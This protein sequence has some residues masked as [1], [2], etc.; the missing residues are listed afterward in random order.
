MFKCFDLDHN[1]V[2]S[3]KEL[4]NLTRVEAHSTGSDWSADRG[5]RLISEMDRDSNGKISE[6]EFIASFEP[7]L[8]YNIEVFNAAVN[9]FCDSAE[10]VLDELEEKRSAKYGRMDPYERA[11]KEAEDATRRARLE[12]ARATLLEDDAGKGYE[13]SV[14]AHAIAVT[15]EVV[16]VDEDAKAHIATL[17][18]KDA[19]EIK[20]QL[21]TE[22]DVKH[23]A[24]VTELKVAREVKSSCENEV[25]VAQDGVA[26]AKQEENTKMSALTRAREAV[27]TKE[28]AQRRAAKLVSDLEEQLRL[29][30][31]ALAE[32]DEEVISAKTLVSVKTSEHE[33]AEQKVIARNVVLSEKENA[34]AVAKQVANDKHVV[35]RTKA[36]DA[37]VAKNEHLSAERTVVMKEQEEEVKHKRHLM[38]KK[39]CVIKAEAETTCELQYDDAKL[40]TWRSVC[41]VKVREAEEEA[42]K[43]W[44][45]AGKSREQAEQEHITASGWEDK[46][47]QAALL[48]EFEGTRFNN[49]ET[50]QQC[51][52]EAASVK[53][54]AQELRAHQ[55]TMNSEAIHHADIARGFQATALRERQLVEASERDEDARLAAQVAARKAAA[56]RANSEAREREKI[57]K[58]QMEKEEERLREARRLA[59][60]EANATRLKKAE[61]AARLAAQK[62]AKYKDRAA[63]L[64]TVFTQWDKDQTCSIDV[65]E[66]YELTKFTN[67]EQNLE[68]ATKMFMAMDGDHSGAVDQGEFTK[69]LM[70]TM[71]ECSDRNFESAVGKMLI[72]NKKKEKQEKEAKLAG[73]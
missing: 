9:Q 53:E 64:A 6:E 8:S 34:L 45:R 24:A 68:D 63:Q 61:E 17:A 21:R 14:K 11:V 55:K 35:E 66:F 3:D 5:R 28:T 19:S 52:K 49:E 2:L 46:A 13:F 39:E 1:G 16:A 56:D 54:K 48:A 38:A 37:E 36:Q 7:A 71:K 57:A 51:E 40:R 65:L 59:E 23:E 60:E 30:R 70:D 50:T 32:A 12:S 73:S 4:T 33:L 72:Y 62:D 26:M 27:E 47:S 58:L 15:G 25:G 18:A 31:L 42:T 10:V 29:A 41:W 67:P 69:Y 44:Q 43:A 20:Q 22:A